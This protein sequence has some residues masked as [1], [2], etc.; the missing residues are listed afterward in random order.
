MV[1]RALDFVWMSHGDAQMLTGLLPEESHPKS[2][3]IMRL[4]N[5]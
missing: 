4:S 2:S 3:H 5:N 1:T